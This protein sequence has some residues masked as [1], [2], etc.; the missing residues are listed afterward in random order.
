MARTVMVV[1][2]RGGTFT[3]PQAAKI[4]Q[5][6]E[7]TVRERCERESIGMLVNSRLRLLSKRDLR[8]VLAAA[9][10]VGNPNF[11]KGGKR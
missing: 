9:R 10:P 3:V 5:L 8:R 1:T 6:H 2:G 11:R 4:L 7:R